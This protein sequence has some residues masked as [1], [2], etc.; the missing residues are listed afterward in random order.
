MCWSQPKVTEFSHAVYH[1]ALAEMCPDLHFFFKV[2][3]LCVWVHVI[4][5]VV[6]RGQAC[7]SQLSPSTSWVLGIELNR[8]GNEPLYLLCYLTSLLTPFFPVLLAKS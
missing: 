1:E 5:H 8:L 2:F 7:G 6:V 3:Y 4:A